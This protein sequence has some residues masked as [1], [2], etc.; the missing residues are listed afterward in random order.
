MSPSCDIRLRLE[1]DYW[2]DFEA[3][4]LPFLVTDKNGRYTSSAESENKDR[5]PNDEP[6]T[7]KPR[8]REATESTDAILES[9]LHDYHQPV[10]K[11]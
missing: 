4:L 6:S 7:E 5:H 11:I 3:I 2:V 1:L 8:L 10:T 9:L